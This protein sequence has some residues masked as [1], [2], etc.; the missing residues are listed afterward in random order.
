MDF[1]SLRE[2]HIFS[3]EGRCLRDTL[4]STDVQKLTFLFI[5]LGGFVCF[6]R[7]DRCGGGRKVYC[8]VLVCSRSSICIKSTSR[9]TDGELKVSKSELFFARPTYEESNASQEAFEAAALTTFTEFI[10]MQLDL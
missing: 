2:Y 6:L 7:V 4:T 5:L 8:F 1:I 9:A 10:L 3:G